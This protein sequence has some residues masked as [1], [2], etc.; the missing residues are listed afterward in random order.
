MAFPVTSLLK[1]FNSFPGGLGQ[2]QKPSRWPTKPFQNRAPVYF[3]VITCFST[4]QPF[5]ISFSSLKGSVFQ[6]PLALTLPEGICTFCQENLVSQLNHAL[7]ILQVPLNVT[8]SPWPSY[9]LPTWQIPLPGWC[10]V[11]LLCLHFKPIDSSRTYFPLMHHS[12]TVWY[13]VDTH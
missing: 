10:L 8:S 1:T 7:L 13:T 6:K 11:L 5:W 12:I 4:F 2:V 3:C 9:L